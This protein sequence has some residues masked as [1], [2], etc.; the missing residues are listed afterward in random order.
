MAASIEIKN[1]G[2]RGIVVADSR[3]SDVIGDKGKLVYRG[4]DAVEMARRSTY[5]E[6]AYLLL[7]GDL[8]A[9]RALEGFDRQ[10]REHRELPRF[11]IDHLKKRTPTAMAMDVLQSVVSMMPDFD[12][13]AQV[14]TREANVQKAIRLIE[15]I[16]TAVAYWHRIRSGLELIPPSPALAHSVNFLAMLNGTPPDAHTA[17]EFDVCQILHAE[18]SFNA[19]TFASRQISSTR[20]TIYAAIAAALGALSG[21]LHGGANVQVMRML[22]EI[23][24]PEKAAEWVRLRLK[25]G[26]KIMGMGHAVYRTQDPRAQVMKAFAQS[27]SERFGDFRLLEIS[28]EVEKTFM[29]EVTF[30]KGKEIYPN[31]DFYSPIVFHLMGIPTDLFTAVFAVSRIAGWCAHVLEEKFAEAQPKPALYRPEAEYTGRYCG[32]EACEYIPVDQR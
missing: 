26:E 28:R 10:L 31:V 19:S 17:R 2:L 13:A 3:I 30:K 32:P 22:Q 15:Q 18:H 21:E 16:P 7:Y 14:E 24:A 23:G 5:E 6:V 11:I 9:R 29:E 4:Y 1:I 12:P 20:A 27:L 8:P 25:K